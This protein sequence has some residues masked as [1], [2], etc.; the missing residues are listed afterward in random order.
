M[1]PNNHV[2]FNW[3]HH[4]YVEDLR[5]FKS[6]VEKNIY[7]AY[8]PLPTHFICCQVL[9]FVSMARTWTLVHHTLSASIWA[10]TAWLIRRCAL[11]FWPTNNLC[12]YGES[13]EKIPPPRTHLDLMDTY[14]DSFS[15]GS[16]VGS[17]NG[18]CFFLQCSRNCCD[19]WLETYNIMQLIS[20]AKSGEYKKKFM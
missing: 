6:F 3:T 15:V 18:C 11:N 19:I 17:S 8:P 13:W 20:L 1:G 12:R 2:F 10:S 9:A 5:G 16:S 7:T 14:V 4:N